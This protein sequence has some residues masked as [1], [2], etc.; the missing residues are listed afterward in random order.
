MFQSL[1]N[2]GSVFYSHLVTQSALTS[3]SFVPDPNPKGKISCA[4]MCVV[5]EE[6]DGPGVCNAFAVPPVDDVCALGFVSVAEM[7]GAMVG[8]AEKVFYHKI[9]LN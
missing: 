1:D 9:N 4:V 2:L 3:W 6:R 5:S 8:G 7:T